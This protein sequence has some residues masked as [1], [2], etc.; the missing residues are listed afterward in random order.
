MIGG[1]V[2]IVGH[3]SIADEVKIAAQSGVGRTIK[4]KGVVLQGSPAFDFGPY[5]KSYVLFKN[6]PKLREQI[7]NLEKEIKKLTEE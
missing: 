3:L 5:Q 1:Q 7:N 6:L 2:G 4:E